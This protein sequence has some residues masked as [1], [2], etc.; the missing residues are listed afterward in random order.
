MGISNTLAAIPLLATHKEPRE[1]MRF[2]KRILL[3]SCHDDFWEGLSQTPPH[4]AIGNPPDSTIDYRST[5]AAP[6]AEVKLCFQCDQ[7]PRLDG[8]FLCR[9]CK[10]EH[11]LC[12][13]CGQRTRNYPFRL[14]Q[15]CYEHSRR[16]RQS[17]SAPQSVPD[18]STPT[19]APCK[20][21]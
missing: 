10:E 17:A 3:T 5:M 21:M 16:S 2:V 12:Y 15:V 1:G 18:S 19:P 8:D 9:S 20:W 7:N 4:Y 11:K 6:A 14:C 13:E